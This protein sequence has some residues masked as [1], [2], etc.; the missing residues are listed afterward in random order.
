MDS[1]CLVPEGRTVDQE[2]WGAC[3]DRAVMSAYLAGDGQSADDW[4]SGPEEAAKRAVAWTRVAG[5]TFF[6]Q[7]VVDVPT[8]RS[9]P[10]VKDLFQEFLDGLGIE[11]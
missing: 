1:D 10:F 2:T 11:L 3:L 4:L 5:P 6:P 8:K 9:D 7:S